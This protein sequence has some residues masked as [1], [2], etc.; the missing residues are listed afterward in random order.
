[1]E[2]SNSIERIEKISRQVNQDTLDALKNRDYGFLGFFSAH[3]KAIRDGEIQLVK[4]EFEK[5]HKLAKLNAEMQVNAPSPQ[6]EGI[7]T[8]CSS[9]HDNPAQ[10]SLPIIPPPP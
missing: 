2:N 5:R 7:I 4:D 3:E 10:A 6:G 8:T 9:R 1:M